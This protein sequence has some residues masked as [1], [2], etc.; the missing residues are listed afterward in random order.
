[1]CCHCLFVCL[2]A[3]LSL[4]PSGVHISERPTIFE[5]QGLIQVMLVPTGEHF[6]FCSILLVFSAPDAFPGVQ[7][8]VS[9]H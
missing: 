2:P 3:C 9:K 5:A 6:Y 4:L 8:T 7:P 1:M